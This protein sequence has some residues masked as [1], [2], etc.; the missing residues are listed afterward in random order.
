M[1]YSISENWVIVIELQHVTKK[2]MIET[3]CIIIWKMI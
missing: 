1:L 2:K 3:G